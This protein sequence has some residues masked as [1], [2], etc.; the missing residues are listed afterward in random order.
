MLDDAHDLKCRVVGS[1]P[2]IEHVIDHAVE[3]FLRRVPGFH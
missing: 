2:V 3:T 1:L